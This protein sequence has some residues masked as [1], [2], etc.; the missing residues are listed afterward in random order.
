MGEVAPRLVATADHV[1]D[2]TQIV[3][4]VG[5]RDRFS[6]GSV[7]SGRTC[8]DFGNLVVAGLQRHRLFRRLYRSHVVRKPLYRADRSW[9]EA[10]E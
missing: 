4:E 9:R 5:C 10:A 7:L 1:A 2:R 3:F 8:E 6:V